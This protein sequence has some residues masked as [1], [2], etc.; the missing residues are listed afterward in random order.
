MSE[1]T[2][3]L[4]PIECPVCHF[5]NPPG[6]RFCQDCGFLLE[7]ERGEWKEAEEAIVLLVSPDGKEYRL[8]KGENILGREEADILLFYDRA[9]SRRHCR[10]TW[11]DEECFLED[12]GSTNGTFLNG[13]RINPGER[14][15]IYDGDEISVGD[16]TF[17]FVCPFRKEKPLLA[18]GI[19]VLEGREVPIERE[20]FILGRR[21]GDLLIPDPYVS[22][23]HCKITFEEGKAFI[24]DLYSTNGTFLNG[25]EIERGKKV[26]LEDGATIE[27]GG[28][29]IVFRYPSENRGED[30]ETKED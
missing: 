22:S 12:L 1:E 15:P 5:K 10:I 7:G 9:V 25:E 18:K 11:E 19:L 29:K 4:Q 17:R 28:T 14:V 6:E 26:L 3:A 30:G 21:E 20:E 8:K 2:I 27:I 13:R 16:S 23:R 24:E